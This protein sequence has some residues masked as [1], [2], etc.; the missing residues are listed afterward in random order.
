MQ[1]AALIIQLYTVVE[2]TNI[3]KYL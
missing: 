3:S 2:P 1:L